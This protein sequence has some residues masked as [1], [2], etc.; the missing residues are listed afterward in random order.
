MSCTV[1]FSPV[2]FFLSIFIIRVFMFKIF[3]VNIQCFSFH[4]IPFVRLF[5]IL[6]SSKLSSFPAFLRT[7]KT[8][9]CNLHLFIHHDTSCN[10]SIP[11][12]AH[13]LDI[14]YPH[15]MFS[16]TFVIDNFSKLFLL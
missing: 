9:S 8:F 2:F 14:E 4:T 7:H 13:I 1:P 11:L 3:F 12:N 10:F 15:G 5:M 6:Y 16:P